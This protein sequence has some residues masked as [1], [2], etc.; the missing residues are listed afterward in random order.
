MRIPRRHCLDAVPGDLSQV[1]IIDADG[2]E[3]GD[4]GMAALVGA[5]V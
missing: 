2:A 3:V 5:D 1:R 4:V